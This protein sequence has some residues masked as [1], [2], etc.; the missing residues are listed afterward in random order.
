MFTVVMSSKS[1]VLSELSGIDG[2]ERHRKT[3]AN[4][5]KRHICCIGV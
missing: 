4:K 3:I 1:K 5:L 2:I